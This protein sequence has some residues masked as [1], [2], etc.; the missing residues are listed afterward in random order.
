MERSFPDENGITN[1]QLLALIAPDYE[2]K[3]PPETAYH[4]WEWF[5]ELSAA[6]H[7]DDGRP[8]AITFADI[9]AWSELTG[10]KPDPW[11]VATLRAMDDAYVGATLTCMSKRAAKQSE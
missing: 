8:K 7:Y 1:E 2:W 11:E 3:D 4:L 6:R 5:H 10:E 9:K